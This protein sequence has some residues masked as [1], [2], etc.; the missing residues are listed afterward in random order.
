M[1]D[2]TFVLHTSESN[3]NHTDIEF[4]Y[5]LDGAAEFTLEDKQYRLNKDDFLIVN[6]DKIHSYRTEGDF[7][8]ACVHFSYSKLCSMMKQSMVF[9]WCNTAGGGSEAY[10]EVRWIF[11]KIV[12]EEY[13]N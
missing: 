8:G 10:D 13:Y 12:S 2:F 7:L 5:V 9:F 3:H 11:R 6:V 4:F 1:Y